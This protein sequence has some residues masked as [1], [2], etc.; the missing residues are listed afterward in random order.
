MAGISRPDDRV[1]RIARMYVLSFYCDWTWGCLWSENKAAIDAFG[2]GPFPDCGGDLLLSGETIRLCNAVNEWHAT[3]LN[4][5]YPPD[6][7][8]WRQEQCDR[9]NGAVQELL[10]AIRN[11]LGEQFEVI[12]K[13]ERAVEDPDLDAY[14]ADPKNFRRSV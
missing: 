1:D 7:G 13:Q 8:P 9:L 2:L 12:D 5:S 10:A 14:L 3:S 4:Q 6:P 11:D